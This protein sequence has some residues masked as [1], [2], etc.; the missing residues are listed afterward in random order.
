MNAD[1]VCVL[2]ASSQNDREVG[3]PSEDLLVACGA[4]FLSEDKRIVMINDEIY[5]ELDDPDDLDV[6]VNT[7]KPMAPQGKDMSN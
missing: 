7:W 1:L 5:G 6:A 2:P 4:K 3:P